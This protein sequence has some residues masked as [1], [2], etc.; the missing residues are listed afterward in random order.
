MRI[1]RLQKSWRRRVAIAGSCL[2]A[3]VLVVLLAYTV[4]RL[5]MAHK[6]SER[7]ARITSRGEPVCPGDLSDGSRQETTHGAEMLLRAIDLHEQVYEESENEEFH[8]AERR[9]ERVT[10]RPI[11]EWGDED[12]DAVADYVRFRKGYCRAVEAA[13]SESCWIEHDWEKGPLVDL[14]EIF[15]TIIAA[16]ELRL[17]ALVA[18]KMRHEWGQAISDALLIL[19]LADVQARF[20][21]VSAGHRFRMQ[22]AAVEIVRAAVRAQGFDIKQAR[23]RLERELLRADDP[24]FL[25]DALWGE[26]VM[27]LWMLNKW[28][29]GER[30]DPSGLD[31][32]APFEGWSWLARPLIHT[33]GVT[34][35]DMME[36]ASA[37]SASSWAA[38]GHRLEEMAEEAS[39]RGSPYLVTGLLCNVP[40]TVVRMGKQASAELRLA[41]IALAILDYEKAHGTL[42]PELDI[43][44]PLLGG[45]AIPM[46][47]V[48]GK[49]FRYRR[50]G[51]GAQLSVVPTWLGEDEENRHDMVWGFHRD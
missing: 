39:S 7:L 18:C 48:S 12:W 3:A 4:W 6:F 34:F 37:L 2:G 35:L 14:P 24:Q 46:D 13:L 31:R 1:G 5:S 17:R 25:S 16:T 27:G 30:F 11:D 41:R 50:L 40:I 22:R 38:C 32:E 8:D 23:E 19:R 44:S 21:G 29:A 28:L 33:D 43:L 15:P 36:E 51:E 20:S 47:P 26:R 9:K 49:P 10:E 42:P 45:E